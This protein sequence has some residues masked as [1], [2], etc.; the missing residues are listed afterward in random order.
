MYRNIYYIDKLSL[1][2]VDSINTDRN[3]MYFRTINDSIICGI[4]ASQYINIAMYNTRS[5]T[6]INNYYQ[7]NSPRASSLGLG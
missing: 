5:K 6:V 7:I 3:Y 2:L 4:N 1:E